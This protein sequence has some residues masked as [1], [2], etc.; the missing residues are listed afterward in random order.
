MAAQ[1]HKIMRQVLE[2]HGCPEPDAR[3]VLS[4]LRETCYRRL[5][6]L[7]DKVCS[8]L[9]EPGRIDRIDRLEIDLGEVQLEAIDAALG[10]RF[11]AAFSRAL[12]GVLGEADGAGDAQREA[13]ERFVHTGTAPWWI[14]L[15]D[16]RALEACLESLLARAPEA[17]R[18]ILRSAPDPRRV[19]RRMALAYSDR[20]LARVAQT[21]SPSLSNLLTW[22]GEE[23]V[24]ALERVSVAH[25]H[26]AR[27]ARRLWWEEMLRAD[28]H[29][30]IAESA[31]PAFLHAMLMRISRGLAIDYRE[32]IKAVVSALEE[33]SSMSPA[34]RGLILQA[35]RQQEPSSRVAQSDAQADRNLS[36]IREEILALI[37]EI[38]RSRT[39]G[40]ELWQTL[41]T[42]IE[43][44]PAPVGAPALEAFEAAMR[45][46]STARAAS[47]PEAS[48]DA[49]RKALAALSRAVAGRLPTVPRG[50]PAA[51]EFSDAD[52]VYIENAGLVI[53]WPFLES[54]FGL[55]GLVE[56][57]KF[58][59][60]AATQRAAGLLHFLV[61]G[62]APDAEHL[63]P[64]NKVLCG[65]PVEEVFDFG[66]PLTD[67]E[68]EACE[69]LLSAAIA[70]AP[71]L[72]E[73]SI[74]GFRASFLLRKGQLSARGGG[75][76]LRVEHATHDIVLERFP[77]G[78]RFVKLP[79]MEAPMQVEWSFT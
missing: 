69:D 75:W 48:A 8:D 3:R 64:L 31:T 76:L 51:S 29:S 14:D 67:A 36:L 25:G 62:E 37:E 49:L 26:A 71:I 61:T 74:G 1:Q 54:F 66:P 2:L 27:L 15:S 6:P 72:R 4:A 47:V 55:L 16:R 30:V 41:R 70:Q 56:D 40:A 77:W 39:P 9:S 60:A 59:D 79:W 20:L 21:L 24:A 38:D 28:E 45:R 7:I 57:K 35:L 44:L 19:R 13:F 34:R 73:M 58:K 46:A 78:F 33:N 42:A 11:E 43:G 22:L 12:S 52:E 23:W 50:Q 53:L 65:M 32:L 10:G 63:L 5:V 17:V 68:V 18:E